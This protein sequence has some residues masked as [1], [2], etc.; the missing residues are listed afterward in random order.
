MQSR[1]GITCAYHSERYGP[2]LSYLVF[3]IRICQGCAS[4]ISVP[5]VHREWILSSWCRPP[6]CA[7]YPMQFHDIQ[8]IRI[9]YRVVARWP[10]M[11]G[12]NRKSSA[13]VIAVFCRNTYISRSD[14]V[15]LLALIAARDIPLPNSH[16]TICQLTASWFMNREVWH[17]FYASYHVQFNLHVAAC[18]GRKG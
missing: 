9:G 13:H 12:I 18:L 2:M 11:F 4:C 16:T 5:L 15:G 10:L 1:R 7:Y 8:C 3:L 17:V 6:P 14:V